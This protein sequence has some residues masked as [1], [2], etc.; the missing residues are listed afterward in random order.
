MDGQLRSAACGV[1]VDMAADIVDRGLNMTRFIGFTCVLI[2][3]AALLY[4]SAPAR[5]AAPT[6]ISDNCVLDSTIGILDVYFCESDFGPDYFINSF[7]FVVV[8]D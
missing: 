8:I 3:L 1:V 2:I 4:A 6:P 7:G 5:A